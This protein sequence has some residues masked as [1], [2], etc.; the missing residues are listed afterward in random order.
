LKTKAA[1]ND[2]SEGIPPCQSS[3][4][5]TPDGDRVRIWSS[6]RK[7][8]KGEGVYWKEAIGEVKRLGER[9]CGFSEPRKATA[10]IIRVE[11]NSH[12][13]LTRSN[14]LP[15][16]SDPDCV[17]E[18]IWSWPRAL[19]IRVYIE[20]EKELQELG[21]GWRNLIV[22]IDGP[23]VY[24]EHNGRTVTMKRKAFKE[25]LARNRSYR[26]RSHRPQLRLVVSNP[27]RDTTREEAA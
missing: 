13:P 26:K 21:C 9:R 17:Q 10:D 5:T 12:I 11:G 1:W 19:K 23:R 14:P 6:A 22:E 25:F 16:A 2:F 3:V 7:D 24:L 27:P 4:L 15:R 18:N 20:A 8:R